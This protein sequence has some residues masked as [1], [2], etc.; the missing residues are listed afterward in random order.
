MAVRNNVKA[1]RTRAD[2]R[3]MLPRVVAF[4]FAILWTG[5]HAEAQFRM[6][7]PVVP[8]E[9]FNVELALMF[10]QPA[11]DLR[12]QTG[13]L[14]ADAQNQVDFVQEL[15]IDDRRFKE[16]RA[17]LKAG[18]RHKLRFSYLPLAYDKDST[19]TRTILFGA[20]SFDGDLPATTAIAWT[21]WRFGYQWDIASGDRAQLGVITEIKRNHVSAELTVPDVGSELSDLTVTVPTIGFMVR[22]YVHRSIAITAE[23]TGFRIP[24]LIG[25]LVTDEDLDV[26][27]RDFD[28]YATASFSRHFGIQ[29]GYRSQTVAYFVDEERGDLKSK[30]LYF[31]AL[32][33]F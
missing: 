19:L 12:I 3:H 17:V 27:L 21:Q 18:R 7:S 29:G 30:G 4:V 20:Q 23:L 11:P 26:M 5:G 16:I 2:K 33:R 15:G 6:P 13:T 25:R 24:G 10:W 22:G 9:N 1:P 32:V 28:I 14:S 8:G 31:G